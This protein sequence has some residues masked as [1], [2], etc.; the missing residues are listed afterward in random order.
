MHIKR[1]GLGYVNYA[2]YAHLVEY[3]KECDCILRWDEAETLCKSCETRIE[4][5]MTNDHR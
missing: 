1:N 2:N 3:C 5:E 4:K